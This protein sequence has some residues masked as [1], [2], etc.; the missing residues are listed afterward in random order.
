M[1]DIIGHFFV[2]YPIFTY[3]KESTKF[4]NSAVIKFV[5]NCL[6]L[7]FAAAM[8]NAYLMDFAGGSRE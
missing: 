3:T 7:L 4:T 5:A 6:I 2:L 8:T 1:I